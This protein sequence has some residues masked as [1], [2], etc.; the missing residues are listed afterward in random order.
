MVYLRRWEGSRLT[1]RFLGTA[2]RY[3]EGGS[4]HAEQTRVILATGR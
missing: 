2:I 1:Y 3:S 4:T